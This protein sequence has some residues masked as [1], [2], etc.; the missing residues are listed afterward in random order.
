MP[1]GTRSSHGPAGHGDGATLDD[2]RGAAAILQVKDD[3][4]NVPAAVP[5][6]FEDVEAAIRCR[7]S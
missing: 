3:R 6:Y 2:V 1:M 7:R 4:G 5:R